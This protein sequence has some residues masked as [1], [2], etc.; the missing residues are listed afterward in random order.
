MWYNPIMVWLLRSPL[1][2]MLSGN[3]MVLNYVGRK[4]GKAYHLPVSYIRLGETL[5]T[6]SYKRRTWWRNLRGGAPVTI[7]L[8]GKDVNGRAEVVEDE[9]GVMEGLTAFIAG[10]PP[11]ARAFGMKVGVDGQPEPGSLQQ[12]ARKCVIVRTDQK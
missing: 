1:H 4:S 12:A 6:I 11:T 10:N 2:G 5:L 8:Q 7:R 9:Q 3:M